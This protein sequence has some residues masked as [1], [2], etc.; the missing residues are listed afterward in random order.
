VT[1]LA[2]RLGRVE[3]DILRRRTGPTSVTLFWDEE[4]VPCAEHD[5]CYVEVENGRHR[6]RVIRLS[7]GTPDLPG[8]I[9]L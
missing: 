7:F 8:R 3:S 2:A 9:E 4:L 1:R 6:G 5:R